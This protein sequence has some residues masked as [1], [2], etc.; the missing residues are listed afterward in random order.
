MISRWGLHARLDAII[1]KIRH[2]S[3]KI[4]WRFDADD[5]CD[6]DIICETCDVV[7]W[8]RV[9]D[10]SQRELKKRLGIKG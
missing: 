3:H 9:H 7:F 10:L 1:H 8:C 4:R 6:G 5:V 2:P